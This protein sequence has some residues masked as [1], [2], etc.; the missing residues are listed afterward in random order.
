MSNAILEDKAPPS[1]TPRKQDGSL[2]DASSRPI[3]RRATRSSASSQRATLEW[4]A[5]TTPETTIRWRWSRTRSFGSSSG[6]RTGES[7]P[8]V[9]CVR[10]KKNTGLRFSQSTLPQVL[11]AEGERRSR[12]G[13][14][15]SPLFVH[16]A[17]ASLITLTPSLFLS[18]PLV[19]HRQALFDLLHPLRNP[20][21]TGDDLLSSRHQLGDRER[22]R[23]RLP[24]HSPHS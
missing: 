10:D 17:P 15:S 3:V 21:S 12:L 1:P 11:R 4:R 2:P 22:E 13:E 14:S 16:L 20:S 24:D 23:S 7:K 5:W 9:S 6:T 8:V 19:A 18:G